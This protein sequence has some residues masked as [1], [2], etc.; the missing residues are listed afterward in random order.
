MNIMKRLINKPALEKTNYA[1]NQIGILGYQVLQIKEAGKYIGKVTLN[2]VVIEE[3]KI[4]CEENHR[5][6]QVN[7]DFGKFKN[8]QSTQKGSRRVTLKPGGFLVLLNS[9]NDISY[10]FYVEKVDKEPCKGKVIKDIAKL[11]NGDLYAC[12]F[13]H[14]GTYQV[15]FNG[16]KAGE[17]TVLYP[18]EKLDKKEL[19]KPVRVQLGSKEKE[20]GNLK[21]LPMQGM[22]FEFQ[23]KGNVSVSLLKKDAYKKVYEKERKEYKAVLKKKATAK[24]NTKSEK[25]V[26]SWKNPKYAK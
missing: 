23:T 1:S 12:T 16:R 3:I 8:Y 13:L 7:I 22:V 5:N 20:L 19:C 25:T 15:K 26:Y 17:M 9:Q 2:N 6:S 4:D 21:V 14:P 10:G 11:D 18:N 24:K